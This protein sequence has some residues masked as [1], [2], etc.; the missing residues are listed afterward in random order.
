MK[1]EEGGGRKDGYVRMDEKLV[2][3]FDVIENLHTGKN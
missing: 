2:L 1:W 3:N